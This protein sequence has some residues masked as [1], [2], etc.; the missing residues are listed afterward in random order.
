MV[1]PKQPVES[2]KIS[3]QL[4][5]KCKWKSDTALT[6]EDFVMSLVEPDPALRATASTALNAE[7]LRE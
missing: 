5:E 3:D 6:F 7:W 1:A 2:C 4:V